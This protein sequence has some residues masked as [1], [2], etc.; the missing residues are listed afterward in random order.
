V[1]LYPLLLGRTE[2]PFGQFYGGLAGWEGL[3]ALFRF[4]T[5][6]SHFIWVPIDA[7][8]LEHPREG[9]EQVRSIRRIADLRKV[10]PGLHLL[11]GHD[12]TA[13][14]SKLLAPALAKGW[15]SDEERRALS[16]YAAH[17]FV[18]DVSL[19]PD[20]LPCFEPDPGGGPVGS[21][22]EAAV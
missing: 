3:R 13:Y 22:S 9:L 19:R 7:Y 1:K 5:D 16:D 17:L 4:V 18:G 14:Q 10:L 11:V 8:L 12:H 21:V 2:V 15:L 6:K 20:A